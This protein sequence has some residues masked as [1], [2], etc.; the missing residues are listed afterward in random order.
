MATA[1]DRNARRRLQTLLS[2]EDYGPKL[3]RLRGADERRV[4]RLISENRGAEARR[5]ILAADERRLERAR[6][7]RRATL[8]ERAV[9]HTVIAHQA[10]YDSDRADV[11]RNLRHATDAELRFVLGADHYQ[12]ADRAREQPH[13]YQ[14]ELANPFWYH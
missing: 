3:A 5:E 8:L 12:L 9:E 4:L 7:Q 11:R 10:H 14:G 13:D 2:D 6:V 1:A